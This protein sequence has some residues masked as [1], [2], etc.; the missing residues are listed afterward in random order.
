MSSVLRISNLP[1]DLQEDHVASVLDENGMSDRTGLSIKHEAEGTVIYVN[2]PWPRYI[3]DEVAKKLTGTLL[4]NHQLV[5]HA[6]RDFD[7]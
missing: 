1:S 3:A 6:M 7:A 2:L 4:R 5:F